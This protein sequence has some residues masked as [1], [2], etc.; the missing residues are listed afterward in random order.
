MTH[1]DGFKLI[2]IGDRINPGFKSVKALV[3]GN[4]LPGIQAVAVKQVEAGA[5]YLDVTIG[6]RAVSD[7]AF[8]TETIRAIQAVATVPLCFDFP[9]AAVQSICLQAYNRTRAKGALPLINSITEDRWDIM[10]LYKPL[11][12]FKVILMASERVEDGVPKANKTAAEIILTAKRAALRLNADYGMPMDDIFIDISIS[13]VVADTTGLH[14]A[15]L[16]A[17]RAIRQDPDLKGIHIMGGLTN[18]GQ[19]L[20]PKAADGSDLKL[21]LECAFLTL[22]VP[23]GFDAVLATPWRPYRPLPDDNYVLAAYKNFLEQSGSNA[24]RAV[25]KF[26]KA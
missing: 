11:G 5:S 9:T 6:A 13:A 2:V 10:D 1:S 23:L 14:R 12:P 24:L 17:V 25:R 18:I 16:E 8:M 20:P 15:T 26:Y 19:Q 7:P 4:D 22:A 21:S 3:D